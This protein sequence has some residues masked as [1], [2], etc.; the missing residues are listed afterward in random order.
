MAQRLP[1]TEVRRGDAITAQFLNALVDKVFKTFISGPGIAIRRVGGG[2]VCI[3]STAPYRRGAGG[4]S[5][6]ITADDRAA[7]EAMTLPEGAFCRTTGTLKRAYRNL[8]DELICY[9]H[10]ESS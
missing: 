7:L 9:S 5:I 3:E 4:G 2:Q 1:N 10:F 6:E 8:A